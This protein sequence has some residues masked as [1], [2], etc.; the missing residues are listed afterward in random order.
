MSL[1]QL[2]DRF[3]NYLRKKY[4][5]ARLKE[6]FGFVNVD[7]VNPPDGISRILRRRWILFSILALGVD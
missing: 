1:R 4:S 6:R 7:Y 5:A 2:Q 3:R